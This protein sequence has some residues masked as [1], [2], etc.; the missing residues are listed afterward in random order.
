MMTN[1]SIIKKHIRLKKRINFVHI[2]MR[3]L[4]NAYYVEI[5]CM[6][7]SNYKNLYILFKYIHRTVPNLIFP[8]NCL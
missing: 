1:E 7:P 5:L 8:R 4:N 3:N 2:V 6:M